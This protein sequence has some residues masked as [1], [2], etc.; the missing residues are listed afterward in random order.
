MPPVHSKAARRPKRPQRTGVRTLSLAGLT[1]LTLA[2]G[3]A[4]GA[5]VG[6]AFNSYGDSESLTLLGF[7]QAVA[8]P[9][10]VPMVLGDAEAVEPLYQGRPHRLGLKPPPVGMIRTPA[11]V[12]AAW[13]SPA[14][15]LR[16][17][18][19]VE[20][21]KLTPTPVTR[22][23]G[24]LISG[25][26]PEEPPRAPGARGSMQLQDIAEAESD[27]EESP[28][29]AAPIIVAAAVNPSAVK[30]PSE[31]GG[32][33]RIA[34]VLDDLG[35]NVRA[36]RRTIE[37][38]SGVTLAFLPYAEHVQSLV[39]K[40]RAQ[41]H[42]I[43]LHMPMEPLSVQSQLGTNPLLTSLDDA[44][45]LKRLRWALNRMPAEIGINNHMGSRYTG[46]RQAMDM[47]M[48][49][50]DARGLIFVDSRTT[51]DSVADDAARSADV[52]FASRDVFLDNER[53][54]DYILGQLRET[55]RI[56]RRR[57]YA[58]A[59]GHG[60]GV[61]IDVLEDWIPDAKA[62]GFEM[63][64]ISRIAFLQGRKSVVSHT[65]ATKKSSQAN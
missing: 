31:S 56:A 44:E 40:A 46:N 39:S 42:E 59:I 22:S 5:G 24:R 54:V 63:V 43:L 33:A 62:R 18:A 57:G 21:M 25:F 29:N 14:A 37:L 7:S 50:M 8:R 36:T 17:M 16:P 13:E 26:V 20:P 55:E 19:P 28:N 1:M 51:G 64:P 4:G 12:L 48:A 49:E 34:I 15:D 61:T 27:A 53:T 30:R 45:N 65:P 2:L 11:P 52:P 10:P 23:S 60:V 9:M 38:D 3:F 58:V 41:K 47:V 32:G 35:M 6:V